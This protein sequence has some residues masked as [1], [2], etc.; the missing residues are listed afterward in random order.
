MSGRSALVVPVPS[1]EPTVRALRERY[2]PTAAAGMPAHVT[3]LTPFL[4]P[5]ALDDAVRGELREFFAGCAPFAFALRKTGR[6]PD[7][8]YLAPEPAEHFRR[9]TEALVDCWPGC[10]P[11]GGAFDE[12]VPHLTVAHGAD[13]TVLDALAQATRMNLPVEAYAD[14]ALLLAQAVTGGAWREVDRFPFG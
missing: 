6:F 13:P 3:L 7:T 9:L 1:A 2:D 14:H 11:Y 5:D 12:I 10:P 4:P 8:L